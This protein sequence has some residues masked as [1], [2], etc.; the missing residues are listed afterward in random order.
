[1]PPSFMQ[2]QRFEYTPVLGWSVSRYDRF[3]TCKRMYYFDY[4]GKYAPPEQRPAIEKLRK[5]TS[6]PLETG[7]IV[8]DMIKWLLE[9]LLISEKPINQ[10][11]FLDCARG[12]TENYCR[13]K[14][15]CEVYYRSKRSVDP[16]EMYAGV[17]L[18]L[19]NFLE[20]EKFRWITEKAVT[21]KADW[22]VEPP[23]YGETRI[24]GL[25]AFCKVDFL[26]PVHGELHILDWKTGR[27]DEVKHRK[28]LLGY[29]L[30]ATHH[31]N[32][33]V[34][35]VHPVI[36]YLQPEYNELAVD[37]DQA[38]LDALASQVRRE[39]AEMQSFCVDVNQNVPKE[40]EAF[41]MTERTAVCRFCNY[42]ELCGRTVL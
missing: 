32:V 24:A 39:T 42:R 9:R 40:Q 4:Y 17:A 28:Q 6:V 26:F 36:V 41:P 1:M 31:F 18:C 15:F 16:D 11:K 10:A 30:W 34:S 38:S 22:V 12:M 7:N 25:K 19:G 29:A 23:G 35:S 3:S 37:A 14:Q 2:L 33:P 8:H 21:N 13:S 20:S 27:P 5:M